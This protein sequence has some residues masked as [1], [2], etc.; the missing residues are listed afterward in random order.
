MSESGRDA[1]PQTL[2]EHERKAEARARIEAAL[3]VPV[4]R[5]S[6]SAVELPNGRRAFIHFSN[7]PT[8]VSIGPSTSASRVA[9]YRQTSACSCS[10]RQ[11]SSFP[12]R[13]SLI[14]LRVCD[15]TVTNASTPGLEERNGRFVANLSRL[16]EMLDLTP[17][18]DRYELLA[19]G[20]GAAPESAPPT[21]R[22]LPIDAPE[23]EVTEPFETNERNATLTERQLV[24]RFAEHLQSAGMNVSR[25]A[26]RLQGGELQCDLS[27]E[28]RGQLIEAKGSLARTGIRTA[29]GQLLDYRRFEPSDTRVAVLLPEHPSDDLQQLIATVGAAVIWEESSGGFADTSDGAF[30]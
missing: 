12:H 22:V 24:A 21:I 10:G 3:G 28:T 27:N 9:Q 4:R 14:V 18:V 2:N 5:Y 7:G 8:E 6:R 29:I 25:H 30:V 17:Y 1:V 20:R 11:T 19:D 16:G 23:L 13:C 26:Y 15:D